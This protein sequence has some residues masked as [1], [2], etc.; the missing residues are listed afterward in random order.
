M[1]DCGGDAV[2]A[3]CVLWSLGQTGAGSPEQGFPLRRSIC[4]IT[5]VLQFEVANNLSRTASAVWWAY[6][7]TV[8]SGKRKGGRPP[9]KWYGTASWVCGSKGKWAGGPRSWPHR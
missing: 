6:D 5:T 8:N 7:C 9:S 4:S 1:E 3:V 2:C